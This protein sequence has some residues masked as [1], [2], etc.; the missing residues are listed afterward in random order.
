MKSPPLFEDNNN[1]ELI[2]A[3]QP[4]REKTR[5]KIFAD[6]FDDRTDEALQ[7]II[8]RGNLDE[9]VRTIAKGKEANVFLGKKRKTFVAVKIYRIETSNFAQHA[10]YL[11][12]DDEVKKIGQTPQKLICAWAE[13]EFTNMQLA[14]SV[15]VRVPKVI[16]VE[17][18]VIVMEL[19][20]ENNKVCK[21][22]KYAPP[23]NPKEAKEIYKQLVANLHKLIYK[24]KLIHADLSEYNLIFSNKKLYLIDFGQTGSVKLPNAKEFVNRDIKNMIKF[25]GKFKLNVNEREFKE[26]IKKGKIYR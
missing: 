1:S 21:T 8:A 18:N 12:E 7:R 22:L 26:D 17:G 24:A 5:R 25:F 4:E 6:V 16:D 2:E 10:R 11:F 15:G 20:T 19:I 13:K 3:T 9:L 23:K 14:K